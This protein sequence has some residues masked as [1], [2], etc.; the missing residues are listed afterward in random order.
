MTR[1]LVR[2]PER[3]TKGVKPQ[4]WR[5]LQQEAGFWALV[6]SGYVSVSQSSPGAIEIVGGPY[7]G[8]ASFERLDLE[9]TEKIPGALEA[10]LAFGDDEVRLRRGDAPSQ[11]AGEFGKEL[12]S[13]FLEEAKEYASAGLDFRYA[14]RKQ[15]G[16]LAAGRLNVRRTMS[17]RASGRS[18]LL[19]FDQR[20]ITQDTPVN[21]AVLAGLRE[22]ERVKDVFELEREHVV[23]A[24][25]L[26]AYFADAR[27]QSVMFGERARLAE[28]A[29]SAAESPQNRRWAGI[30]KLSAALLESEA[31]GLGPK[32]D[33]SVP[34]SW[35]I[36]LER[37]FER[38][39]REAFERS[40]ETVG[41]S[42][43]PGRRMGRTLFEKP[44]N[45]FRVDPD[46][47]VSRDA[48]AVA[49]ADVKYKGEAAGIEKLVAS[50]HGD[51]YQVLAHAAA[52]ESPV[53]SLVFAGDRFEERM[54]RHSATGAD[55]LVA[56]ID[57]RALD[58]DVSKVLE[59][60]LRRN[61]QLRRKSQERAESERAAESEREVA[62]K[63]IA[64]TESL[65][66]RVS[67]ISSS[68]LDMIESLLRG[69]MPNVWQE[70]GQDERFMLRTAVYFGLHASDEGIDFSGPI[71]G[72]FSVCERILRERI[73]RP[74]SI[75]DRTFRR[76]T[77]GE[78]AVM[79]SREK[80]GDSR[81]RKVQAWLAERPT[82]DARSLRGCAGDMKK[83]N[84]L[85]IAAAH[86]D[87]LKP[88][89]WTSAFERIVPEPDGLLPRLATC[90]ASGGV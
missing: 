46:V 10:L 83:M 52:L 20:V 43:T 19:A 90:C 87:L 70:L 77:F 13:E 14:E 23:T 51:I 1:G 11:T 3:G 6:D 41:C 33:K 38:G 86:T 59:S 49:V 54:L 63:Q 47:V 69:L 9:L 73:F 22:V 21:R 79:L 48:S 17:L 56:T 18:H 71:L 26:A 55:V 85:R 89:Q 30:L 28:D 40:A 50:S 66:H 32:W 88:E 57:P 36:N 5:L 64:A 8:R 16:T 44:D 25:A 78:A 81:A 45:A 12:I 82:I 62:G 31:F 27:T 37:L 53:A 68:Q 42:V 39:V 15:V 35:F 24:R 75:R 72:L 60:L 7:V 80:G 2:V 58:K 74:I 84:S 29:R 76:V 65:I 4:D 34:R 61:D 67:K